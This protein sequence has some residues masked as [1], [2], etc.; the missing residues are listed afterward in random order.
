[1]NKLLPGWAMPGLSKR[2]HYF[3][4]GEFTSLCGAWAFSGER[5]SDNGKPGDVP[6]KDD[7]KACF[8]RR[9]KMLPK[10]G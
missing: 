10:K 2:F 1:M 4:K 9:V 7:C 3:D 6:R 8:K 5:D